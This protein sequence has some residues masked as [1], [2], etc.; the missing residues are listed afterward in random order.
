MCRSRAVGVDAIVA[1]M[2]VPGLLRSDAA[3]FAGFLLMKGLQMREQFSYRSE[4]KRRGSVQ[5]L[6]TS[7]T[8]DEPRQ[9]HDC[10][11]RCDKP[12]DHC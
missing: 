12:A 11:T 10:Q 9:D 3:A 2:R 7:G 4:H 5:R 6:A 1:D 8:L